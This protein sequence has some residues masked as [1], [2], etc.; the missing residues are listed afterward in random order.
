MN[1]LEKSI[2]TSLASWANSICVQKLWR[3]AAR[4]VMTGIKRIPKAQKG[5]SLS[6]KPQQLTWTLFCTLLRRKVMRLS[7]SL[8]ERRLKTRKTLQCG[9][10]R[11]IAG[12]YQLLLP[13]HIN[14]AISLRVCHSWRLTSTRILFFLFVFFPLPN[15]HN[16]LT[17]SAAI[18]RSWQAI[19]TKSSTFIST[20]GAQH[21]VIFSFR[22]SAGSSA[23]QN[24]A[25]TSRRFPSVR[26][27][28]SDKWPLYQYNT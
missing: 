15:G 17:F 25:D 5:N 3:L 9:T 6:K 21:G 26:P 12:G 28:D 8:R 23:P 22:R 19:Y 13:T 7:R 10:F 2:F 20:Y 24:W 1:S 18:S 27:V 16:F 11:R 4:Y 14:L